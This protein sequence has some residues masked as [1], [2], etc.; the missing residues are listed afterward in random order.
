MF[1][2]EILSSKMS[3]LHRTIRAIICWPLGSFLAGLLGVE[4]FYREHGAIFYVF[5]AGY[6]GVALGFVHALI[7]SVQRRNDKTTVKGQSK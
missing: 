3:Y 7:I 2:W 6:V 5:V 1:L 4:L